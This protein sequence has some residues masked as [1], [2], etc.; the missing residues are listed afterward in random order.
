[1][2]A[3][4]PPQVEYRLMQ[5]GK[6]GR[7]IRIVQCGA[8]ADAHY[9]TPSTS[10]SVPCI[11]S[12]HGHGLLTQHQIIA[13]NAGGPATK[14]GQ[15]KPYDFVHKLVMLAHEHR[16]TIFPSDFHLKQFC[17]VPLQICIGSRTGRPT[18]FLA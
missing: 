9:F 2:Q 5:L 13:G 3:P 15:R 17:L 1:M 18:I 6:E 11:S 16:F 8:L 12:L 4:Q 14:F 10:S 7:G